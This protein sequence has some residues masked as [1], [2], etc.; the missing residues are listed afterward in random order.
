MSKVVGIGETVLDIIFKDDQPTAAVP[1]GSTFN[2]MISLGRTLGG[3]FKVVMVTQTGDD[4][5]GDI[6]LDFME[7]SNVSSHAVR[8]GKGCRSNVSL[9]FLDKNNDASYEFFKDPDAVPFSSA[10]L[11]IIDF[12]KGDVVLFGSYFA[13]DPALRSFVGGMLRKAKDAGAT[14]YY[15]INFRKNHISE[16][17][18]LAQTIEENCRLSDYVRG[19]SEDFFFL[20]GCTDGR[21]IYDEH[22]SSLCRN[23]ILTQGAGPVEIYTPELTASFE[24]PQV[25]TVSTIGA[26]DN[27]NAGFIYGLILG[28]YVGASAIDENDWKKL[29]SSATAFSSAVCCSV[30]NY[31]DEGFRP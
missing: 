8:R 6:E 24:V 10:D 4:H 15:D 3:S 5:V 30:F 11:D 20:Y 19:S 7:K 2:A 28:G 27:F 21:R 9:A 1:G 17:S 25:E 13:I 23:L 29:V 26:G 31:V 14:L 22:I 18:G 12:E 16:I